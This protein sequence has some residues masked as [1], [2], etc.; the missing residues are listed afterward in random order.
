MTDIIKDIIFYIY[1]V[2]HLSNLLIGMHIETIVFAVTL[3][4]I[5]EHCG[6]E[7]LF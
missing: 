7:T 3:K 5:G 4:G 6:L 1:I 2:Q